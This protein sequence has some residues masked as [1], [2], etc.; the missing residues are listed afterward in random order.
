MTKFNPFDETVTELQAAAAKCSNKEFAQFHL[1]NAN[2]LVAKWRELSD[3]LIA[4]GRGYLAYGDTGFYYTEINRVAQLERVG[5]H[6]LYALLNGIRRTIE[7]GEA[8]LAENS[9]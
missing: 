5:K 4:F 2:G 3:R 7:K 1:Y 6:Q 9:K 8:F